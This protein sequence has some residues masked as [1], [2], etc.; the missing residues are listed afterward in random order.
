MKII[1]SSTGMFSKP[2]EMSCLETECL[3]GESLEILDDYKGWFFLV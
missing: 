2:E 3:F 1:Y